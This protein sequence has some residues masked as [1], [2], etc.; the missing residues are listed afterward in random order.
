MRDWIPTTDDITAYREYGY[1]LARAVLSSDEVLHIRRVTDDTLLAAGVIKESSGELTEYQKVFFQV[2]NASFNHPVLKELA[3]SKVLARAAGLLAD[4]H[5]VRLFLDQI[6]YK[7][8]GARATRPH[9]DAPFLSFSDFRSLN[10]WIALDD[11]TRANGAL[12]YYQ[13]SHLLGLLRMVHLDQ[14]DELEHDYPHLQEC[15]KATLEMKAGDVAFHNCLTVHRA[16]P[17]ASGN[18]R[19][20]FSIQYMPGGSKYNGWL[21]PFLE[22][23]GPEPGTLLDFEC[24]PIV[25]ADE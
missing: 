16:F 14:E 9:Q 22:T 2:H 25:F 11:T 10:C 6:I 19:H 13:G 24:C 20:A 1:L 18:G 17:N 15:T 21:H 12:E 7:Q 8:P 4:L 23:Y 3:L 5:V